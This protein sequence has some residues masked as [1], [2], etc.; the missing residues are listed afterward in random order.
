MAFAARYLLVLAQDI[1]ETNPHFP[2]HARVAR[3][4]RRTIN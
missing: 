4:P 3:E 2:T 1:W